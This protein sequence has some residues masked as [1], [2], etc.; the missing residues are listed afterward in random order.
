MIKPLPPEA[1]L[2]TFR[3][4]KHDDRHPVT[5]TDL[6]HDLANRLVHK[7]DENATVELLN[8]FRGIYRSLHYFETNRAIQYA[9]FGIAICA[10]SSTFSKR[11]AK[12][13]T[14]FLGM[15]YESSKPEEYIRKFCRRQFE[16]INR[17]PQDLLDF[18][19]FLDTHPDHRKTFI[20]ALKIIPIRYKPVSIAALEPVKD[21]FN[22]SDFID[23]LRSGNCQLHKEYKPAE[24]LSILNHH[25]ET[26]LLFAREP[27]Y[28]NNCDETWTRFNVNLEQLLKFLIR[29]ENLSSLSEQ[30]VNEHLHAIKLVIFPYLKTPLFTHLSEQCLGLIQDLFASP[31]HCDKHFLLSIPFVNSIVHE[32]NLQ[33]SLPFS[34]LASPLPF[35]T[36]QMEEINKLAQTVLDVRIA[37]IK[38]P[39]AT[40]DE[41]LKNTRKT[42]KTALLQN[43]CKV[44]NST[45][46]TLE[47]TSEIKS[48][49]KKIS[50]LTD[51]WLALTIRLKT[52]PQGEDAHLL[53][54]IMTIIYPHLPKFEHNTAAT[55]LSAIPLAQHVETRNL[56]CSFL[57]IPENTPSEMR[58][59]KFCQRKFDVQ[60]RFRLDLEDFDAFLEA[61]P[62]HRYLFDFIVK[63]Q[64]CVPFVN[65][66]RYNYF[67]TLPFD[68]ALKVS[69]LD[70]PRT[71]PST[72]QIQEGG[73]E[74]TLAPRSIR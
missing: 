19:D 74:L 53:G 65:I 5:L 37:Y 21:T 14:S 10:A 33:T 47:K 39:I 38:Q 6:W 17:L 11:R 26:L 56:L 73:Q 18:R 67:F 32:V 50:T 42:I 55:F 27:I 59:S 48:C 1:K 58:V 2:L 68:E 45:I 63:R 43:K 57:E 44:L 22:I 16:V 12:L 25:R 35:V 24:L 8:I 40:H 69:D 30:E 72:T 31:E 62:Q 13:L 61:N 71:Y 52:D 7:P 51:L 60:M 54:A 66:Q 36:A 64:C 4:Q 28:H 46:A 70:N 9:L 20:W 41:Q 29:P 23:K 15:T 34:T 3:E 49:S